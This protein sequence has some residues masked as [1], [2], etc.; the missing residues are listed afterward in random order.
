MGIIHFY[1][2]MSEGCSILAFISLF[3]HTQNIYTQFEEVTVQQM[4]HAWL[5]DNKANASILF[6]PLWL[7]LILSL[8]ITLFWQTW[9]KMHI[10]QQILVWVPNGHPM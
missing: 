6:F 1:F 8:T 9:L 2:T 7:Y 4:H 5:Y 10:E 3:G